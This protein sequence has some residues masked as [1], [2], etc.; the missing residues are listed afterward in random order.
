M[1]DLVPAVLHHHE[2]MDGQGYPDGLTGEQIPFRARVLCVA[3][4]LD[5]MTSD[6]PYRRALPV[7]LAEA[8][9]FR[10]AGTQFDPALVEL[11]PRLNL[12][13]YLAELKTNGTSYVP[14]N[15]YEPINSLDVEL[16]GT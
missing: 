11:I 1:Q 4:C 10:C 15:I 16:I 9:V 5:A 6:R 13:E 3:D 14:D 12:S 7:K 8:E 2:R